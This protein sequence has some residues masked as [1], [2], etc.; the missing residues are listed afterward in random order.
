MVLSDPD[1]AKG[2]YRR[3]RTCSAADTLT[4]EALP[5]LTFPVAALFG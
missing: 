1:A 3:T 4:S 2:T 5:Q